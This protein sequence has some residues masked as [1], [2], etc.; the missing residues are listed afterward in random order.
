MIKDL[1][2]ENLIELDYEAKTKEEAL[3]FMID[4]LYENGI[5]NS[6]EIFAKDVFARESLG[7]TGVGMGIAIPH[8]KSKA[9]LKASFMILRLAKPIDWNSLDGKPVEMVIMLAV[10]E[11]DANTTHLKILSKLAY[12]LMDDNFRQSLINAS[13]KS[14]ILDLIEKKEL[15]VA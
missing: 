4:M 10:P 7:T 14:E 6:K 3:N 12:F 11:K 13:S 9:V 2:N 5:I 15:E 8:G 1:T